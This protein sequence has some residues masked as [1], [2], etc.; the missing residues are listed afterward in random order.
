MQLFR[1]KKS[2]LGVLLIL[3]IGTACEKNFDVSPELNWRSIKVS[4]NQ[5]QKQDP[6]KSVCAV[7]AADLAGLK[8]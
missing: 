5:S 7:V 3:V 1:T 4:Q 8:A 6:F 2:I